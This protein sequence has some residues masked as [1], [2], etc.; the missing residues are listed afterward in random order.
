MA[1]ETDAERKGVHETGAGERAGR[2]EL[3]GLIAGGF[4]VRAIGAGAGTAFR[5]EDVRLDGFAVDRFDQQ[6]RAGRTGFDELA[7]EKVDD[8]ALLVDLLEVALR[9]RAGVLV[10][11]MEAEGGRLVG[12]KLHALIGRLLAPAVDGFTEQ[13]TELG[14]GGS[15][16]AKDGQFRIADDR[17]AEPVAV[18]GEFGD[19]G[20]GGLHV[21]V[22]EGDRRLT[23]PEGMTGEELSF[24]GRLPLEFGGGLVAAAVSEVG[25]HES[26]DEQAAEDDESEVETEVLL[27]SVH[28]LR[29]PCPS[30]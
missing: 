6:R 7:D 3:I 1:D 19:V 8:L 16:F 11:T 22:V 26:A 4:G 13:G 12:R 27:E 18:R 23:R 29:G 2:P 20:L 15:R 5:D 10:V 25:H 30:G 14:A 24:H 9:S 28:G 21:I 17:G